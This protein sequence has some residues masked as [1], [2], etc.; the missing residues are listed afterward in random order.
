MVFINQWKSI[1]LLE[2]NDNLQ[3]RRVTA[4]IDFYQFVTFYIHV[5]LIKATK[6]FCFFEHWFIWDKFTHHALHMDQ[7]I[8]S[9]L[10]VKFW[11]P[12]GFVNEVISCICHHFFLSLLSSPT[13]CPPAF[14]MHFPANPNTCW[15]QRKWQKVLLIK[16]EKECL[17]NID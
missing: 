16:I 3:E 9:S 10:Q 7:P 1:S 4:R 14:L 17:H 6:L 11:S 8:Y 12:F 15:N 13:R 2:T 5:K